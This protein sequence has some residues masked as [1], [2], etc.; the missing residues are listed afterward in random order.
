MELLRILRSVDVSRQSAQVWRER[1][2]SDHLSSRTGAIPDQCAGSSPLFQI[3]PV[4]GFPPNFQDLV[5][6]GATFRFLIMGLP[7]SS[8][9]PLPV[10]HFLVPN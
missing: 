9:E 2:E 10:T 8:Q 1:E 6:D 4:L 5:P 7:R 3:Q